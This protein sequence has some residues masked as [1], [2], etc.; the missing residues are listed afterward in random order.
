M[1]YSVDRLQPW[2]RWFSFHTLTYLNCNYLYY[3]FLQFEQINTTTT[4]DNT[5][6]KGQVTSTIAEHMKDWP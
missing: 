1:Y 4:K 3:A 5:I 6:L 2:L